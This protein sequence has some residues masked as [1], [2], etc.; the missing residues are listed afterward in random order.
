[1]IITTNML[2]ERYSNYSNPL[3]NIK[4]DIDK[5]IIFRLIKGI[6]ETN[7]NV[8]S[9]LLASSILSHLI[10]VMFGRVLFKHYSNNL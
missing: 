10:L 9:F 2:R 1:M 8:T 6:Y 3:D 7:S 5:G 4:W